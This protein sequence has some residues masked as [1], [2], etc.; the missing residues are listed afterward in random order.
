MWQTLKWPKYLLCSVL[1]LF[2]AAMS[3]CEFD[4]WIYDP[5]KTGRW[6]NT[7]IVLPILK[8]LDMIDEPS[9]AVAG[10]SQVQDSDLTPEV[11]EY[12]IGAG[13]TMQ[14][15]VFE[16]FA[17]GQDFAQLR[18]VDELGIIRLP[19][20]GSIKASGHT[21]SSLEKYIAKTL[22]D[23]EILRDAM[24]TV[25]VTRETQDTFSIVGEPRQ[26]GM[27]F[28]TYH[29]PRVDFRLLD[30]IALAG[31]PPGRTRRLFVF[32]LI[33]LT[34]AVAGKKPTHQVEDQ[35]PAP[36]EAIKDSVNLIEELD[37]SSADLIEE[38]GES[39]KGVQ[40]PVTVTPLQSKPEPAPPALQDGLEGTTRVPQYVNVDGKW[41]RVE[42]EVVAQQESA[43]SEKKP[44]ITQRIIEIPLKDL[45]NGDMR[46][47]IVVRAG[48]VIKV[49]AQ[50]GG[51]VYMNGDVSRRGTF[52]VPG[53]NELTVT[54]VVA[55]AGGFTPL[56]VPQ[57][58]DLR[59]R[60]GEEREA[61]VRINLRRIFEGTQPNIFL[62]P[63][64]EIVVG[65]NFWATPLAVLRNGFRMTYGFGFVL[66]R[67]FEGEIF[68]RRF[69]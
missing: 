60:I 16:L 13:D 8:Q 10:M 42:S 23:R 56:A 43:V 57:R 36:V 32:R 35:G 11:R 1:G 12:V 6:E 66:D 44:V 61:I 40:E 29:I 62:K 47:N 39:L 7:P 3:G 46:F 68:G 63:N 17:P 45:L 4:S 53:E 22:A 55:A 33:P 18:R 64:D 49:P 54:Q 5:S 20:L 67:N 52:T 24:V 58:A 41:V 25:I 48:D 51:F 30:A 50:T 14:V 69:R 28:G 26:G 38:L 27:R 37:K 31:G 34:E 65:T 2:L 19:V 59:R 21:P 9:E 15:G